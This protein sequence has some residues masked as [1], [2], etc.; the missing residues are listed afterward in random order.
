MGI[1][2]STRN[3]L[4]APCLLVVNEWNEGWRKKSGMSIG[5][6]A[7]ALVERKSEEKE[8]C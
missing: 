5:I 2:N 4:P 7:V 8:N 3:T 1:F 6:V